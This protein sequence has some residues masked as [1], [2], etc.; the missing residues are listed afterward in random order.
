MYW[1]NAEIK[2]RMQS[3]FMLWLAYLIFALAWT[4][5]ANDISQVEYFTQQAWIVT[6]NDTLKWISEYSKYPFYVLFIGFI[7]FAHYKQQPALRF[8][9]WGYVMA[10]LI[11]SV[12]IVRILKMTLGHAR[13]SEIMHHTTNSVV[14]TWIGTTMSSGYHSFPSGHTSDFLISGV[15]LAIC[16]PKTW[17]RILVMV[18]AVFNGVLRVA[19]NRHFPLDVLG[20]VFIAGTVS[21]AVW[22]FWIIPRLSTSS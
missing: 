18:F 19:L 21:F 1:Q 2:Q 5:L 9:G 4:L 6:N 17:M 16:L 22:Q 15:F 20:G 12:L 10:Q 8:V 11:G 3:V 13:P 14:D 7:L